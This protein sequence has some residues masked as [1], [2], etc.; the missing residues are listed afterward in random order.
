MDQSLILIT[1]L[2]KLGVSAAISS[3]LARS[4]RFRVPLFHENR[5]LSEKLEM[6]LFIGVPYALGVVVRATVKNF[7]A[8]DLAF[9]SAILMGIIAGRTSG[10]V[11]ALLVSV[12]SVVMGEWANLPLNLL[13]GYSAGW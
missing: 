3:V 6:V 8:A 1:L 2:I 7:V 13:A 11:G 9:E 5:A 4:R 12:P 10:V